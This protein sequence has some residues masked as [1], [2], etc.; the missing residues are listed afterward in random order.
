MTFERQEPVT[1]VSIGRITTTLNDPA[2]GS[3]EA[4]SARANIEVLMSDGSTRYINANVAEHF[5]NTVLNQLIAFVASVRNK[6]VAEIL[7]EG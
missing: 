4:Q 6:A 2:P 7:P 5:S 3:G 1:A